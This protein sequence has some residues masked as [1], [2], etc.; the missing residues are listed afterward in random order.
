MQQSKQQWNIKAEV[1]TAEY[2]TA[3]MH[4]QIKWVKTRKKDFNYIEKNTDWQTIITKKN[5][6]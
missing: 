6:K 5:I 3:T 2:H 1:S 4:L